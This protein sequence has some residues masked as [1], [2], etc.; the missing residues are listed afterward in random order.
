MTMMLYDTRRFDQSYWAVE[1]H[2]LSEQTYRR[3]FP[4]LVIMLWPAKLIQ[5][6]HGS[7]VDETIN[8]ILVFFRAEETAWLERLGP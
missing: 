8:A 5:R 2:A 4:A 7:A 1:R 3:K 6:C